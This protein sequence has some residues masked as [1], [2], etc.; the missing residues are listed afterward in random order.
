M[1]EEWYKITYDS[2]I[3]LWQGFLNFIP[4]LLAAIVVF[5]IGWFIAEVIGKIVAR[6]LRVLKLDQ[7]FERAKWKEALEA[8]EIKVKISD[9]IGGI[10]K[11]VLVIVILSISVEILGLKG[12]ADLLHQ[13]IIWL[14]NLIV[15]VAIFVVAVIVADILNR[16]IKASVQKIGIKYGGFLSALV[17]WAIYVFAGLAI[18]D[19]LQ[20]SK[21]LVNSLIM[22]FF[23]MIA[24][25]FGLAFGL[26]GK[27]PAAKL[28][29]DLK[30]KISE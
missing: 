21:N 11:W 19:Q 30:R 12:F 26:G 6:I 1:I 23:G 24:L 14:P 15:A 8:A 9:F 13:L 20:V 2:L 7:I 16:L 22:A 27:E 3:G 28:I 10:C 18:L 29:E 4:S 25:A 5:V 17:R